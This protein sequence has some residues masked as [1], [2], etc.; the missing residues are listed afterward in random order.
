MGESGGGRQRQRGVGGGGFR[1]R[2]TERKGNE[3]RQRGRAGQWTTAVGDEEGIRAGQ[4][5][6]GR[7]LQLGVQRAKKNESADSGAV[8]R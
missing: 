1:G 2:T 8:R 5:K 4:K 3:I 7:N 6:S